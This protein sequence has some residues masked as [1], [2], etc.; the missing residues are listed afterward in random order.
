VDR[1]HGEAH[2]VT[3]V[4]QWTGQEASALRHALRLTIRDFADHLGVAERTV[5]KWEAGGSAMVPVPVM[6]AALD[7]VLERASDEAKGRFGMLL[8]A[9]RNPAGLPG[10][11]HDAWGRRARGSRPRASTP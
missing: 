4:G 5:A 10:E 7:T 1:G 6:Q 8:A 11:R 2:R 9:T 3:V